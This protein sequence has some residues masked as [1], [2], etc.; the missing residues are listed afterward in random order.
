MANVGTISINEIDLISVDASPVTSGVSASIGSLAIMKDGTTVF[1]KKGTLD[2]DWQ[3]VGDFSAN[4]K[5][6]GLSGSQFTS[7]NAAIASCSSPSI[8]NRY[9]ILVEPGI[10]TESEITVPSYI[11][12]VGLDQKAVVIKSSGN[13]NVFTLTNPYVYMSFF[14]IHDAPAGYCGIKVIDCDQ[15]IILHKLHIFNC[16]KGLEVQST[17]GA[18]VDTY[19]Y[20]E[21]CDLE[22]CTAPMYVH[23][24]GSKLAYSSNE[25]LYTGNYI[26]AISGEATVVTGNSQ[27]LQV[28]GFIENLANPNNGTG[29]LSHSGAYTEIVGTLIRNWSVGIDI[30]NTGAAPEVVLRYP[31]L[32]D[33]SMDLTVDHTTSFGSLAFFGDRSK[34]S[35]ASNLLTLNLID[36]VNPA[37]VTLGGLYTGDTYTEISDYSHAIKNQFDPGVVYGG[38]ITYSTS[39][40]NIANSAGGGYLEVGTVPNNFLKY[41]MFAGQNI[42]LTANT[43]NFLYIDSN[44]TLSSSS[45]SPSFV[46]N[47]LL[48]EIQTDSSG[49]IS[50]K[51]IPRNTKYIGSRIDEMLKNA[52]GSLY[53]SGSIATENGS[54]ARKLNVSSGEYY[55]GASEFTPTGG[56]NINFLPVYRDG[57]GGW[58]HGSSTDLVASSSTTF[59]YDNNSGTLATATTTQYVNYYLYIANDS[60]DEKYFLQI[61]QNQYATLVLAQAESIPSKPSYF[62][63]NLTL[64]SRITGQQGTNNISA[65]YDMRPIFT[66]QAV[67]ISGGGGTTDHLALTNLTTGNS[68][69]TQFLMLDGSTTMTGVLKTSAT[70]LQLQLSTGVNKLTIDSGTSASAR[71]Y[72]VPDVGVTAIFTMLE[73][74]QTFSGVK[75]FSNAPIASYSTANKLAYFDT[76]KA[77]EPLTITANKA[78]ASDSNGLPV[79]SSTTDVE[80]G[81]VSGVTS[82]IQTQINSKEPT[83]TGTTSADYYRG[84]KTFQTLNKAAVGLS[85]VDNIADTAKTI[86]GDVTGTLGASTVVKLQNR[87]L[88][89][90]A[91]TSQQIIAWNSTSSQ[92]EPYS[93]LTLWSS[94][95]VANSTLTLTA[96]S[97]R[98]QIFT[99]TI[100]G[101]IVKLPDATTLNI[102][103]SFHLIN[104]S[105]PGIL[106]KD[107][108]SNFLSML[109]PTRE[110]DIRVIN[111]STANG[112]WQIVS[113]LAEYGQPAPLYDDFITAATAT[114]TIGAL[115]WTITTGTVTQIAATGASYGVTRINS[116]TANNGQGALNLGSTTQLLLN[117]AAT[118]CDMMISFPSIGGTGAA[119]FAFHGGLLNATTNL[120]PSTDPTVGIGFRFFG[121][122]ATA[123]N[124][125]A[126]AANTT[127]TTIDSAIQ[128]VAGNW[129]KCSFI[130]NATGTTAYFYLNNVFIGTIN[131]NM[132]TAN[133]MAPMMKVSTTSTNAAAKSTDCDFYNLVRMYTTLR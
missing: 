17:S 40:L 62:A 6:V 46:T 30:Q 89:S 50:Y 34:T 1:L 22:D 56:S 3:I 88:A 102:G 31:E 52:I 15:Y 129:Y 92:W 57:S 130:V 33:N 48:G 127:V 29:I 55:Y 8:T 105:D 91:P 99:G 74:A 115:G 44:G 86:A 97:N 70:T 80:L 128:V 120:T 126:F 39:S 100:G 43:Y 101:Q 53:F 11:S 84:D 107:N 109:I 95:T 47:I 123:A 12:L 72:S 63:D 25:N 10:Y 68:G 104:R 28:N 79:G 77:L 4:V 112:V 73:G 108:G 111:N 54:N 114:G 118:F 35:I 16:A 81:Y 37:L 94:N 116:S 93:G 9:C 5:R 133:L 26:N 21:F 42:T 7:I 41:I 119:G 64:I 65:I 103:D 117:N 113:E 87:T 131:T 106:I 76:S 58:T 32:E 36:K 38:D 59:Q 66:T 60:S 83:I 132:P 2:T 75:T 90:T 19:V 45:S 96:T 14:S 121:V 85:N 49:V 98:G 124:I 122:N 82:A 20:T 24:D 13:H 110:I 69:H 18:S 51:R 78:L 61:G 71:T 23:S 67:T 125:F 27:Y